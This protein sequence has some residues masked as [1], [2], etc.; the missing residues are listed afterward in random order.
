MIFAPEKA[1]SLWHKINTLD[2]DVQFFYVAKN[3]FERAIEL[4]HPTNATACKPC[5]S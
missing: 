1:H 3:K 5:I 2:K 4:N